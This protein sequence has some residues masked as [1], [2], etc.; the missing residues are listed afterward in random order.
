MRIRTFALG[1][2]AILALGSAAK[3]QSPSYS[4]TGFYGGISV[5]GSFG[6]R[7]QNWSPAGACGMNAVCFAPGN[8]GTLPYASENGPIIPSFFGNSENGPPTG[9]PG[10][11]NSAGFAPSIGVS[12]GYNRQITPNLVIGFENQFNIFATQSGDGWRNSQTYG[13]YNAGYGTVSGQRTDSI[14]T[15]GSLRWLDLMTGRIGVAQDRTLFYVK[16]G[17]ALGGVRL[18]TDARSSET[19]VYNDGYEGGGTSRTDSTWNGSK[20][21]TRAGFALG[22]GIEH[23]LTDAISVKLDATYFNLGKVSAMATG[24]TFTTNTGNPFPAPSPGAGK[25]QPYK[26]SQKFDGVLVSIGLN[27]H[28]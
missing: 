22:G 17:L 2:F 6:N 13:P 5:G 16:G 9:W 21:A 7:H 23:A 8:P 26:V 4:W 24:T 11:L 15:T 20:S 14:N 3:A 19:N 10:H 28:Y 25:A 18:S 27:F 12:L 1:S